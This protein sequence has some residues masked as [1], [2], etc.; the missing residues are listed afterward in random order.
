M[1]HPLVTVGTRSQQ[2]G[3]HNYQLMT[4]KSAHDMNSM[5]GYGRN[6][7]EREEL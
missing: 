6:D 1:K 2:D 3:S 7:K 5:V 4:G